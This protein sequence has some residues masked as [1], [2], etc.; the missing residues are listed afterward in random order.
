MRE[1]VVGRILNRGSL[2]LFY[3]IRNIV[4][5]GGDI[6]GA[7]RSDMHEDL[8][9]IVLVP[10]LR[11]TRAGTR[12]TVYRAHTSYRPTGGKSWRNG[13]GEFLKIFSQNRIYLKAPRSDPS[14]TRP[15]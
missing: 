2:G 6:T 4:Q 7:R 9:R 13:Q 12:L 8:D 1:A 15:E 3:E 14:E 10:S 11:A 5:G